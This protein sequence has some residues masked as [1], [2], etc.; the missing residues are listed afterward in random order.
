[1]RKIIHIDMDCFYASI[2]I[3]DHPELAGRPVAVGGRSRRGVLTTAS[4]EARK[5]GCH[6]AMPTYKALQLCPDLVLMPVRFDVYRKE[7]AAIREVF[8]AFT[9]LVEPLS[10]DEAYLDVS[11]LRSDA[12]AV[13]AEIRYRIRR[14]TGL[15]ASAGIAPNKLLAKIASDWRKPDGQFE[16]RAEEVGAFMGPLPVGKLWGVGKKT[17]EKI[18]AFGA[19]TCGELQAFARAALTARFGK[20]G[21]ELYDQCRGIDNRGVRPHRMRK[22]LANERTFGENVDVFE[23]L[24]VRLDEVLDDQEADLRKSAADRRVRKIFVKLKFT[25]FTKTSV[26]RVADRFD[27]SLFP[28]LLK[29]AWARRGGKGV[30][31]LGV[32]V[33]FAEVRGGEDGGAPGEP[34]AQLEM[35]T[36]QL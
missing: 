10:L 2:E 20:F 29:E 28:D 13:A 8:A 26:E 17:Q 7:S 3:R 18:E 24:L 31:L 9:E 1:M 11:H 6:S 35:F 36:D 14:R 25:D 16:I 4:Y 32:G 22:S 30:R 21:G 34:G 27:R 23:T 5:F 12:A 19:R 15:T 33:R